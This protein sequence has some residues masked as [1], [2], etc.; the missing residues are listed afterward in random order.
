M[1]ARFAALNRGK[2]VLEADLRGAEGRSAVRELVRGA[3]V[4]LHSLAPAKVAG[5]GLDAGT[6]AAL[7]PGLVYAQASGG[8]PGLSTDYPSR[9]TPAWP[10]CWR[11]T[12]CRRAPPC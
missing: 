8:G 9:R 7:R 2:G 6:V 5:L 4:L 3:D 12:G 1:S 11:R 10:H